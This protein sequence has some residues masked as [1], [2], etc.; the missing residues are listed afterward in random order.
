M[1]VE[2]GFNAS[3]I[4][5]AKLEVK[6]RVAELVKA[7]GENEF[8]ITLNVKFVQRSVFQGTDRKADKDKSESVQSE[9]E[10]EFRQRLQDSILKSFDDYNEVNAIMV[11][12]FVEFSEDGYWH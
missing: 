8:L 4:E 3:S 5:E 9:D 11:S 12:V 7:K 2:F 10:R 1:E 6:R